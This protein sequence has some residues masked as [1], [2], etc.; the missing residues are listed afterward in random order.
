MSLQI[1]LGRG[2]AALV[3]ETDHEWLSTYNW[4]PHVKKGK[5]VYAARSLGGRRG[6]TYMHRDILGLHQGDGG[7]GDHIDGNTLDNRR[8]NLRVVNHAQN[9]MNRRIR[10]D[11]TSGVIGVSWNA[12]QGR[13]VAQVW[14]KGVHT[15]RRFKSFDEAVRARR[16]MEVEAYGDYVRK[17]AVK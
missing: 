6:V 17:E 2:Y 8:R 13:W 1:D 7:L 11:N 10:K 12:Y 5:S 4:F 15:E 16:T 14:R 3:D 9:C